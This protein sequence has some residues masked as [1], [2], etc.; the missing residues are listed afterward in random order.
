M[1]D[2][3]NCALKRKRVFDERIPR[4]SEI[5]IRNGKETVFSNPRRL[6][7]SNT[8]FT[9]MGEVDLDLGFCDRYYTTS[10]E[11]VCIKDAFED[12][13][14]ISNVKDDR[15]LRLMLILFYERN[16][17]MINPPNEFLKIRDLIMTEP[18]FQDGLP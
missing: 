15:R 7:F 1:P 8:G 12:A 6:G 17:D 2:L 3:L 14:N 16:K 10:V 11:R 5:L 9:V 4:D 18:M 13:Y